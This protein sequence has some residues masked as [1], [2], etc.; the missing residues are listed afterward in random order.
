LDRE[1]I[2]KMKLFLLV[3]GVL[4]ALAVMI[5]AFGAHALKSVL[6]QTGK[7]EVF[8]TASKYHFYHA[9]ALLLLGVIMQK[10]PDLNW[11]S[12][13]GYFF[14]AGILVFSGS[15]YGYAVSQVKFIAMITPLGGL[16]FIAGW[17]ALV[18]GIIK[19]Y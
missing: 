15:L 13:A 16:A 1:I 11:W 7:G 17:I 10:T 9:L 5:G 6:E 8:E 12:Y 14:I 18:V 4:A 2:I 3:G 19:S